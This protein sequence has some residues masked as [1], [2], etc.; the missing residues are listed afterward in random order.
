MR[1]QLVKADANGRARVFAAGQGFRVTPSLP[2]ASDPRYDVGNVPG[3][4]PVSVQ[5]DGVGELH[6]VANADVYFPE[7]PFQLLDLTGCEPSSWYVV[8]TYTLAEGMVPAGQPARRAYR[9]AAAGTAVPTVAPALATDGWPVR[10]GTQSLTWYA[11][12]GVSCRLYV[13][14]LAG[15]WVDTGVDLDFSSEFVQTRLVDAPGDRVALKASA[16]GMTVELDAS[17][18]VG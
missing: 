4:L 14:S 9:V 5:I 15:N 11:T 17:A 6:H 7:L 12:A 16:G 18:E 1:S 13:R 10:P 3:Q 8:Q 2:G